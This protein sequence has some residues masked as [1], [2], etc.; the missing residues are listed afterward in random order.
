MACQFAIVTAFVPSSCRTSS[1]LSA[2]CELPD[3]ALSFSL[4]ATHRNS[5]TVNGTL[6]SIFFRAANRVI[7]SHVGSNPLRRYV[8]STFVL[9]GTAPMI[10]SPIPSRSSYASTASSSAFPVPRP[11]SFGESFLFH[12]LHSRALANFS[13]TLYLDTIWR[14]GFHVQEIDSYARW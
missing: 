10:T 13:P 9:L 14:G 1:L 12:S 11:R 8:S 7:T 6:L 2:L 3:S 5:Q 4:H